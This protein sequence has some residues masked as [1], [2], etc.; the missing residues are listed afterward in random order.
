M[1]RKISIAD[2]EAALKAAD[3]SN[4]TVDVPVTEVTSLFLPRTTLRLTIFIS[5]VSSIFQTASKRRTVARVRTILLC[6]S[7]PPDKTRYRLPSRSS[8]LDHPITSLCSWII[9]MDANLTH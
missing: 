9:T 3:G 5:H 2:V 1:I 6:F 8:T 7:L 4:T